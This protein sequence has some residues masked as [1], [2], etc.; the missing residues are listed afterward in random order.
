MRLVKFI[1]SGWSRLY[2]SDH[3]QRWSLHNPYTK[4]QKTGS[5]WHRTDAETR[6]G[7]TPLYPF[8]TES[9]DACASAKTCDGRGSRGV[10]GAKGSGSG[11]RL[12]LARPRTKGAIKGAGA[13]LPSDDGL[14]GFAIDDLDTGLLHGLRFSS[15]NEFSR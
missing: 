2:P 12:R 6:E 15:K 5:A 9:I 7:A 14:N 13:G 1:I 3:R 4:N 10:L 8:S 11:R